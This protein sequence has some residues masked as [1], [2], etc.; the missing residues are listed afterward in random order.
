MFLFNFSI[1]FVCAFVLDTYTSFETN[2]VWFMNALRLEVA[3]WWRNLITR[4]NDKKP[5]NR[6]RDMQTFLNW[7]SHRFEG[8]GRKNSNEWL[9]LLAL[10][11]LLIFSVRVS[12]WR[13]KWSFLDMWVCIIFHL[14]KAI[15]KIWIAQHICYN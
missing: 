13:L 11:P 9:I 12:P 6:S 4:G 3:S 2:M 5:K 10:L 1:D 7:K 8:G 14:L 15:Y